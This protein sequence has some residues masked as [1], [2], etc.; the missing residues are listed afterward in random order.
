MFGENDININK[1][2]PRGGGHL[3]F[4]YL[5]ALVAIFLLGI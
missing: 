2:D 3:G 4:R 1:S 5:E